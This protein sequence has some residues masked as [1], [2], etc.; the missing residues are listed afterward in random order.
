MVLEVKGTLLP[1]PSCF[2]HVR[3]GAQACPF[4]AGGLSDAFGR[5]GSTLVRR[6]T[7][8]G[9]YSQ[10]AATAAML[11]AAGC[12]DLAQS[13]TDASARSSSDGG[14]FDAVVVSDAGSQQEDAGF[15]RCGGSGSEGGLL[16]SGAGGTVDS[17]TEASDDT[18]AACDSGPLRVLD[19]D[20]CGDV[21]CAYYSEHCILFECRIECPP[22]R[23]YGTPP[24]PPDE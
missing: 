6:K 20:A 14:V 1:C 10:T 4:C 12:G 9:A 23:P 11:A 15:E 21:K 3:L 7:R 16:D 24:P 8:F 13:V 17:G 5:E 22:P 2:R 18:G 19:A